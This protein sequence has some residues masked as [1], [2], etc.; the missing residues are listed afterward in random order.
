LASTGPTSNTY[1]YVGEQLDP[2]LNLYY[3]RARYYKQDIGR[4]A[5]SDRLQGRIVRPLSLHE[6][7]Y[8]EDDPVDKVDRSGDQATLVELVP[9]LIDFTLSDFS[10][11][12]SQSTFAR[13]NLYP[14]STSVSALIPLTVAAADVAG[15]LRTGIG[16]VAEMLAGPPTVNFNEVAV[17]E[18]VGYKSGTCPAGFGNPCAVAPGQQTSTGLIGA[19]GPF[20]LPP[21][22]NVFYD[23]HASQNGE[24][25]CHKYG[26]QSCSVSC[27]QN[28]YSAG[29][30]IG[31]FTITRTFTRT[32]LFGQRFTLVEVTKQ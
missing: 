8:S 11:H 3:L 1:L 31:Q 12:V 24:S 22:Y 2:Q 25:L 26:V 5:S 17:R 18:Q 16:V 19:P 32:M 28:Y 23:T 4:F 14:Q 6:Y 9:A 29:V 13:A 7:L 15:G 21:K 20:G 30:L 10:V 27:W